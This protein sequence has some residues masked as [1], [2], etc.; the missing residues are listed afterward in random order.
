[1]EIIESGCTERVPVEE[2]IANNESKQFSYISHPGVYHKEK[3][4]KIR[5]VFDCSAV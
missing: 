5:V 3:P 4:G 1:M 2:I